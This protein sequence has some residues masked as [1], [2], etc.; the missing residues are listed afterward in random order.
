M[1]IF[2]IQMDTFPCSSTIGSYDVRS[3]ADLIT[4]TIWLLQD[5]AVD[6]NPVFSIGKAIVYK[7]SPG[8]AYT[9]VVV[10]YGG[11]KFQEPWLRGVKRC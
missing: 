2:E 7:A 11:L 8:A 9:V 10:L 5:C 6:P 4:D 1:F 3:L